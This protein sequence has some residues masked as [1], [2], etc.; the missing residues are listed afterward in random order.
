MRPSCTEPASGLLFIV[1]SGS[2]RRSTHSCKRTLRREP[3]CSPSRD[4][5]IDCGDPIPEKRRQLIP[6]VRLC[7][8]CQ[9]AREQCP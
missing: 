5:C 3:S 1:A 4:F 9:V 7:V 6:G 8:H 2:R